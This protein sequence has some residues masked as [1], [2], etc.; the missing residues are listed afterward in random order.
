[1]QLTY[2]L[3]C[4]LTC[5]SARNCRECVNI[6]AIHTTVTQLI[7]PNEMRAGL[8]SSSL[9]LFFDVDSLIV[10][11]TFYVYIRPRILALA[12]VI[13]NLL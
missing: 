7:A 3:T 2:R 6:Q 1:M 4:R 9:D 13:V 12:V 10:N 5:R 8:G 11:R